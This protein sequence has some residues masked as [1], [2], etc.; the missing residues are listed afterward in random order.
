MLNV[1]CLD[2][3]HSQLVPLSGVP[4]VVGHLHRFRRLLQRTRRG[5][6]ERVGVGGPRTNEVHLTGR[7]QEP[8]RGQHARS[9]WHNNRTHAERRRDRG[10][11]Q[12]A[13]SPKRDQREMA[14][15]HASLDGDNANGGDHR[16][17]D[18]REHPLRV[19]AR[20]GERA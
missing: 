18:H 19:D 20:R 16:L 8:D 10:C 5:L 7:G 4:A 13:C 6:G 1:E 9:R 11:V 2:R 3:W 15:I 17:V 14:R 12:R